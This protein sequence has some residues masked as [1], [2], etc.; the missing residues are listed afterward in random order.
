MNQIELLAQFDNV[1]EGGGSFCDY[2]GCGFCHALQDNVFFIHRGVVDNQFENKPVHLRFWQGVGSLLL[3]RVLGGQNHERFWQFMG[4]MSE[5][6]LMLLH[7]FEQG[8]LHFSWRAINFIRK[9]QIGKNRPFFG[10]KGSI[11]V[12]LSPDH[13]AGQ[14]VGGELDPTALSVERLSQ[15]VDHHG[16]CHA[17]NPFEENMSVAEQCVE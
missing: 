2:F 1:I 17:G 12:N 9:D 3:N 8:T 5:C 7:R 6:H 13:V 16:F 10:F 15:R 14:Q 11:A 4:F